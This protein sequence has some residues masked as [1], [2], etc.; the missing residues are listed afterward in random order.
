M[1]IAIIK[2]MNEKEQQHKKKQH[3]FEKKLN[4]KQQKSQYSTKQ[5]IKQ[6]EGIFN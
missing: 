5:Y 4:L 2:K 6:Q 1:V 3:A